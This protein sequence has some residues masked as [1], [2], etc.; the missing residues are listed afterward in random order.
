MNEH[1]LHFVWKNSLFEITNLHTS[2]SLPLS[3]ID[4]GIH[5][6]DSGPDFLNARIII[7]GT[8]WAGNVEIH[9]ESSMWYTHRHHLDRAYNNVIL[10][11]V[12]KHNRECRT[13]SGAEIETFIIEPCRSVLA[14]YNEY[15][16]D[17]TLIVCRSD[18]MAVDSYY[19]RHWINRLAVQRI[20]NR[21]E[22]FSAL[23]AENNSDW[24]ETLYILLAESLGMKVNRDSFVSL[25]RRLPLKLIR[26]HADNLIQVEALLFGQAG[27]LGYDYYR[28]KTGDEYYDLLLREYSIL[29]TKYNLRP[30]SAWEWKFHRMRPVNFPTLRISQLAALIAGSQAL[31]SRILEADSIQEIYK[32]LKVSSSLYWHSH[33]RFGVRAEKF[34]ATFGDV[35]LNSILINVVIPLLFFYGRRISKQELCDRAIDFLDS[36]PPENNRILR[37]WGL[38]GIKPVSA[39]ETQGLIELRNSYC[40]NRECLNCHIGTKLI[41]LGKE[42]NPDRKNTLDEPRENSNE[43]IS[44]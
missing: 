2:R 10:H 26:K 11:V 24:E 16:N 27:M 18:L 5:N 34:S 19:L 31:F 40:K 38:A 42:I 8:E 25:A 35:M 15:M 36:L 12:Y 32:I 9:L 28:S 14:R 4:P 7:D 41:S 30:M 3:I 20:Q 17:P 21:S 23:L 6:N 29:K 43:K 39:L 33:Y 37:E 1:F 13:Q 44:S 22:K